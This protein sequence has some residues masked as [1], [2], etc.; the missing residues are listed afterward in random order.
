MLSPKD[1]QNL[2]EYMIG[3]GEPIDR[4]D[5]GYNKPDYERMYLLGMLNVDLTDIECYLVLNTLKRY[6]NTQL[7]DKKDEIIQ[8]FEHYQGIVDRLFTDEYEKMAKLA[9]AVHC[10]G[11]SLAD[12]ESKELYFIK[13]KSDDSHICCAFKEY[14]DGFSPYDFGGRWAK[15]VVDGHSKSVFTVS[16]DKVDDFLTAVAEKGKQGYKASAEILEY[17]EECKLSPKKEKEPINP[18]DIKVTYTGKRNQYGYDLYEISLN[19]YTLKNE[20]WD[21]KGNALS[22][23]NGNYSD[24]LVIS[25]NE[26]M[27]PAF[28]DFCKE[29]GFDVSNIE[30]HQKNAEN[31]KNNKNKSNNK[32][33]D[34][35]ELDLPFVPYPFQIED[36]Q[37]VL[38]M[39]KGMLG[40]EMGC[41][42][43]FIAI[44]MGMSIPEKKLVICPETL[45]LNWQREI[46]QVHKDADI[47]II[48]S[49]TKDLRF[50]DDWTI[51][52]YQTA[53]KFK[54]HIMLSGINCMFVDEAHNC[55][56][57][58]SYGK[59]GSK[60]A[61]AV[62]ALADKMEYTYLMTGTP[63]PT[64]NKDLYNEF[65][66]L[67][68]IDAEQKYAFHKY[69]TKFCDAYNSG[70]G[71]NYDGSSNVEELHDI[72]SKYMV[73]RLK[74]D[75]LPDLEKQRMFIPIDDKLS[76]EYKDMEKRLYEPQDKDT[77]M[78]TAMSGL[79]LLS[80]CKIKA[81]EEM[82]DSFIESEQPVVIVTQFNDTMDSLIDH[83]GDDCCYIRGGMSD[84][85]KQKA[86]DDFQSG[87]KKVCLLNMKA[88]K[89][90][91]TLT[92][93][94][95][96]LMC[97]YEWT[98]GNIK[99]VE[100]RICR[101]GQTECC[102]IYYIHHE[103][104][105]LDNTF[106]QMITDKSA[107]IDKI[108]DN[109]E[110]TTNLTGAKQ[111]SST[112]IDLLKKRIEDD[113]DN[114]KVI[115]KSEKRKKKHEAETVDEDVSP[116][117]SLLN[118]IGRRK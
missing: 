16:L 46:E 101:A 61:A 59:P 12:I 54:D 84:E 55:K 28:L 31:E 53:V 32:L 87:E 112:F 5:F 65:V 76:K 23:V 118:N 85:Q 103:Q 75:V 62:M 27:L 68:E 117:F 19:D 81:T 38:G 43:T 71:W 22:Y 3:R 18:K 82:A 35:S 47:T 57:V 41:G 79:R 102:N 91:V 4:D 70:Y 48:R 25:S 24:K 88:G 67:G 7:S 97:D 56:A 40:H 110:N 42:K 34:V 104:S 116:D 52:G 66:L 92:K 98:P 45:R 49:N 15:A 72:L 106:M 33:I 2:N 9:D 78:G 6:V 114:G 63:M 11:H 94:H 60:R 58:N 105:V 69:G 89:E 107:N 96:M 108:I 64:R 50:G 21:L 77:F 13:D 30:E 113:I 109:A 115:V 1:I 17:I 93:S 80:M 51:M 73:R 10:K 100:D 37:A 26:K 83:Y 90:G 74:S 36:A 20:L 111:S 95:T 39:K 29:K 86:I 44:I 99:Q 8:S 14:V